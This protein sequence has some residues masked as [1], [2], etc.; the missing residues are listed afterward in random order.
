MNVCILIIC[1]IYWNNVLD[2]LK[3]FHLIF[4]LISNQQLDLLVYWWKEMGR[5]LFCY[6]GNIIFSK[7]TSKYVSSVNVGQKP[8]NTI[9][10]FPYVSDTLT[11][12]I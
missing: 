3:T 2:V 9:C 8:S 10:A 5:A 12:S 6:I 1:W 4:S 7:Q 11:D